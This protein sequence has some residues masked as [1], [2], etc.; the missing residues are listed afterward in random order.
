MTPLAK[1]S[2]GYGNNGED[3]YEGVRFKNVFGTYL[4]GPILPKNPH[5]ADLLLD[6]AFTRKGLPDQIKP[7]SDQLEKT[8]HQAVIARFGN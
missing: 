5:L 8:A 3:S 6:L 7:M 2:R 1:V 4:H